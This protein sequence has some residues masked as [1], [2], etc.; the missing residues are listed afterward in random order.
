MK[1][2]LF[3]VFLIL[4]TVKFWISNEQGWKIRLRSLFLMCIFPYWKIFKKLFISMKNLFNFSFH[5]LHVDWGVC[6]NN[7]LFFVFM[8]FKVLLNKKSVNL[9]YQVEFCYPHVILCYMF[10]CLLLPLFCKR[11]MLNSQPC[12]E[13]ILLLFWIVFSTLH[14]QEK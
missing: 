14:T 8:I 3:K 12:S 9:W 10:E 1:S 11:L 5:S 13:I 2:V 7:W 6:C 4:E